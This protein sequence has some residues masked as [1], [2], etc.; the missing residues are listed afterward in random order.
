MM[1][2]LPYPGCRGIIMIRAMVK[3]NGI[4][5]HSIGKIGLVNENG[6]VLVGLIEYE[7]H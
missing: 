3:I 7:S 5:D 4:G 2:H 6:P 1:K